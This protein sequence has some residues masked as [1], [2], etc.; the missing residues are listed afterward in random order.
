MFILTHST[1]EWSV[2]ADDSMGVFSVTFSVMETDSGI[3]PH[4]LV[5]AMRW[6]V[7]V[8]FDD[9]VLFRYGGFETISSRMS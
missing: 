4:L 3:I 5:A 9:T 6:N 8:P 1:E 7:M 2:Y